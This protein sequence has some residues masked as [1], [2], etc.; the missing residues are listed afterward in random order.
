[1]RKRILI[2]E[3]DRALARAMRDNLTFEGFEVTTIEEG[4]AAE[5]RHHAGALVRSRSRAAGSDPARS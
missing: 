5:R 3:D 2:V 1:M 4:N